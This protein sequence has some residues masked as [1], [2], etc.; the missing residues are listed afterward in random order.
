MNELKDWL[1]SVNLTKEDLTR[2]DPEAIK[3]YP[4]FIVNK[5]MSAHTDCVMFTNAMNINHY[6]SKD[7]QY[8][9]YLNSIRNK[10]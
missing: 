1:N 10:K 8:H 7:L 2:D 4:P 5:C 9:F 6:L 3:K